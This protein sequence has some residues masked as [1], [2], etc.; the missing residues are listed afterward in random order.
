MCRRAFDNAVAQVSPWFNPSKTHSTYI[1]ADLEPAPY[2]SALLDLQFGRYTKA[3]AQLDETFN[4]APFLGLSTQDVAWV[5]HAKAA[6]YY[7]QEDLEQCSTQLRL[8]AELNTEL[9]NVHGDPL[10]HTQTPFGSYRRLMVRCSVNGVSD[11]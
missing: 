3:H 4:Q 10:G 1:F 5:H 2:R 11:E 6:V 9:L 7:L 8:A